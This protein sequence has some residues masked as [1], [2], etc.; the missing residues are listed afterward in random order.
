[1]SDLRKQLREDRLLRDAAKRNVLADVE[2]V[3]E[4]LSGQ[5]IASRVLGRVGDGAVDVFELAKEQADDKRGIL[6]A[7]VG[8]ILLWLA[9]EPLFDFLGLSDPESEDEDDYNYERAEAGE[10]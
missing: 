7:L 10:G 6:A 3:R 2:N 8:A 5:R 1:M 9:R 4:N